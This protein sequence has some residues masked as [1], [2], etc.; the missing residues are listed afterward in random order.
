MQQECCSCSST[1]CKQKSLHHVSFPVRLSSLIKML[2]A[3]ETSN[4]YI[5]R[6]C[7][8]RVLIEIPTS[9]VFLYLMESEIFSDQLAIIRSIFCSPQGN[10]FYSQKSPSISEEIPGALVL[11]CWEKICDFLYSNAPSLSLELSIYVTEKWHRRYFL[12][13]M[14]LHYSKY[15]KMKLCSLNVEAHSG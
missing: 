4:T 8:M 3:N 13:N 9:A 6:Y 15:I 2:L 7:C 12:L 10:L 14:Q 1:A 11:H 5:I